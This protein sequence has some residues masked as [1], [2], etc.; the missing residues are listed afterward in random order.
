MSLRGRCCPHL[1]F[2]FGRLVF[3]DACCCGG[4]FYVCG[5]GEGGKRK[6]IVGSG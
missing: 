6:I 3:M 5:W 2:V 4:V 1:S